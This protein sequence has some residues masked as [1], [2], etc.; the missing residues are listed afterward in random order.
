MLFLATCLVCSM[1]NFTCVL[2]YLLIT[3]PLNTI[4]QRKII[5]PHLNMGYY[6]EDFQHIIFLL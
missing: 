2:F 1:I 5:S 4:F 6:G 3:F